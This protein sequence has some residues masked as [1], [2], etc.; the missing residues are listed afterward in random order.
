MVDVR[1]VIVLVTLLIVGGCERRRTSALTPAVPDGVWEQGGVGGTPR[2][3]FLRGNLYGYL[4]VEGRVAIDP[5]YGWADT[6]QSGFALCR[7]NSRYS[8]IDES[9]SVKFTVDRYGEEFA[10][11]LAAVKD[12]GHAG[13]VD[14]QGEYHIQPAFMAAGPFSNG[15]AGVQVSPDQWGYIDHEGKLVTPTHFNE[16]QA[17][18]KDY[19]IVHYG[20]TQVTAEDAPVWWEG[21]RWLMIDRS[22]KPLAV[23]REDKEDGW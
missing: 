21:G 16:V 10:E 4:D 1:C 14:Q 18:E 20:G 3:P 19:T 8:I 23:I 11:G 2:V 7:L 9:G 6:F 15:L 22:G 13:F 17:A 5:R 12:F